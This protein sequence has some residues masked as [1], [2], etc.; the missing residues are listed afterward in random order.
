LNQEQIIQLLYLG[1]KQN[2]SH[3]GSKSFNQS[4]P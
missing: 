3:K 2:L 1:R 4:Q